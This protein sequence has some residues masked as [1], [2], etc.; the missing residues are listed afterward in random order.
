MI[1][2]TR[3][4]SATRLAVLQRAVST[5]GFANGSVKNRNPSRRSEIKVRKNEMKL[6]K[7]DF[8]VRKSFFAAPWRIFVFYG[9]I[10]D[11]LGGGRLE[12]R[13]DV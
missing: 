3:K 10:C 9:G 11:F 7:N 13:G 2:P 1:R 4:G 5:E 8:E 12:I 6:R